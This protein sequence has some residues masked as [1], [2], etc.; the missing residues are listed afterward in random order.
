MGEDGYVFVTFFFFFF[1]VS[2]FM[3]VKKIFSARLCREQ[4]DICFKLYDG[5]TLAMEKDG[6]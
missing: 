4:K 3:E 5:C 2:V 1:A 6:T